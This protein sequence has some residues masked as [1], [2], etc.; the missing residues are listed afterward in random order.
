MYNSKPGRAV[1]RQID[2]EAILSSPSGSPCP[3]FSPEGSSDES[4]IPQSFASSFVG[5]LVKRKKFISSL[6]RL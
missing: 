4:L 6:H 3:L 2:N 5:Q 1:L